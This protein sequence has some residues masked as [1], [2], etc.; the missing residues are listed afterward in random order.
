MPHIDE[1]ELAGLR[2]KAALYDEAMK[3][4]P[5]A[6]MAKYTDRFG[7]QFVY[8]T[9]EKS[10]AVEND[11]SG[12]PLPLYAHPIPPPD[13]R[14]AI[15]RYLRA[16]DAVAEYERQRHGPTKKIGHGDPLTVELHAARAALAKWGQ[17]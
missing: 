15:S 14:E 1:Q 12:N 13:V 9:S 7:N 3:Q 16:V 6:W 11:Q 10:L 8:T 4:E 5:V 2:R 17:S